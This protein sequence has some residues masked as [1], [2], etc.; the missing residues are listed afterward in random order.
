MEE[1][2]LYSDGTPKP[3]NVYWLTRWEYCR[4]CSCDLDT[5]NYWP[6]NDGLCTY[7]FNQT[8]E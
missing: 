1:D 8:G 4:E 7:C 6:D 5:E 3:A 2:H